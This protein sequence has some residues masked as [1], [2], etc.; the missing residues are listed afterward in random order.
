MVVLL[1]NDIGSYVKV[2][3]KTSHA[4][5]FCGSSNCVVIAIV[6]ATVIVIASVALVP[7]CRSRCRSVEE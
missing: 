6:V 2:K 4:N 7:Q 3:L 1:K 5:T